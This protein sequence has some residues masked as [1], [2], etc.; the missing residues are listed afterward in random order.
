MNRSCSR[1][2]V[3]FGCEQEYVTEIPSFKSQTLFSE[4]P[5]GNETRRGKL[6][7]IKEDIVVEVRAGG[8]GCSFH[9]YKRSRYNWAQA[10]IMV[11]S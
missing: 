2:D 5:I 6:D 9:C 11:T 10:K 8:D 7:R 3:Y 1:L 4:H